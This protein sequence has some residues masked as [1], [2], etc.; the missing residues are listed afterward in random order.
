MI[1]LQISPKIEC[2]LNL[3]ERLEKMSLARKVTE[4]TK[5]KIPILKEGSETYKGCEDIN[6]FLTKY[7]SFID[8]WYECRCDK[9]DQFDNEPIKDYK[10]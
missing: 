4:S 5:T 8:Q 7:D 2:H 9:Y 1:E 6:S 10:S 3:K